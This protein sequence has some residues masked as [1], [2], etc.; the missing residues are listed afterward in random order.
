MATYSYNDGMRATGIMPRLYLAKGTA[1]EKFRGESIPGFATI[2]SEKYQKNGKWSNTSYEMELFPGV[3]PLFFCSP[4]HGIWGEQFQSWG[5]CAAALQL[6]PDRAQEIV[7][8]EYPRTAERLDKI[9]AALADAEKQSGDAEIV[10]VSFGNPTIRAI[11]AGWWDTP[12]NA[13]ASDGTQ[14]VIERGPEGWYA[15]T[16]LEPVGATIISSRHTPGMHG[17]YYTV[18]VAVPLK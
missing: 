6:A 16:V 7:R 12:K 10:V 18:E 8:K 3:R 9:D 11:A 1:I 2:L 17:G 5:E 4:L 15:P 14:V 13:E